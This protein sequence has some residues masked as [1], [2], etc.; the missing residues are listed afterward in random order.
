VTV[1]TTKTL[2][3]E[4]ALRDLE[5]ELEPAL[6]AGENLIVAVRAENG[7]ELAAETARVRVEGRDE[8]AEETTERSDEDDQTTEEGETDEPTTEASTADDDGTAT[9]GATDTSSSDGAGFG[10]VLALLGVVGALLL[11]RVR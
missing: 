10:V 6:N 1:N 7:T 2:D 9:D 5:L 11:G 3:A 8:T 4:T